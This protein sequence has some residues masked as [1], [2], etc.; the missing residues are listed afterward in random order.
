M[1]SRPLRAYHTCTVD[2]S[3]GLLDYEAI[4]AQAREVR[5]LILQA[6]YGA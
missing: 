5:P 4:E 1:P 2:P 3:T 6:G